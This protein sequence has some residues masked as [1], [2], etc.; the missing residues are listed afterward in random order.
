MPAVTAALVIAG[1]PV[2]PV[3]VEGPVAVNVKS[4]MAET[5]PLSLVTVFAKVSLGAMSLLLM[6]QV[7][8]WPDPSA[9]LLPVNVPAVQLQLPLKYPVGP[10]SL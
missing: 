3:T 10:V 7:A 5:P 2:R 9:K 6:V 1:A 8:V 4:A